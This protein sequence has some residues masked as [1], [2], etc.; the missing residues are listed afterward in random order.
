MK[1]KKLEE[2]IE[3]LDQCSAC[4]N[5]NHSVLTIYSCDRDGVCPLKTFYFN[6]ILKQR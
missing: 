1:E 3:E 4:Q 6:D 5:S 2:K